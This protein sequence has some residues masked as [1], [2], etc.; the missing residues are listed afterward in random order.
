MCMDGKKLN[1]TDIKIHRNYFFAYTITFNYFLP[2]GGQKN[3]VTLY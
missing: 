1:C 3:V 2:Y